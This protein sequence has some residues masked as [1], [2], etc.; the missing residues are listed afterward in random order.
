MECPICYRVGDDLT[1][2]WPCQHS[3]CADCLHKQLR[4]DGRCAVCRLPFS[5]T[6]PPLFYP[7][8]ETQNSIRPV[9]LRR[10]KKTGKFGVSMHNFK[11]KV[12]VGHVTWH[13]LLRLALCSG[14]EVLAINSIPCYSA[15]AIL[16]LL[17]MEALPQVVLHIRR[18]TM[19]RCLERL[20]M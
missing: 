3:F 18:N 1:Q 5:D 11:N 4:R 16:H 9:V 10:Q 15:S 2:L 20:V 7:T 19:N 6:M 12:V 8:A 14:T 13:H 17:H